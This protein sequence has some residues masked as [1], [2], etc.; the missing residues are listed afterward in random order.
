[1]ID[2]PARSKDQKSR[3]GV[4]PSGRKRA[5]T[6]HRCDG[7]S[8][9]R[10][11]DRRSDLSGERAHRHQARCAFLVCRSLVTHRA[12]MRAMFPAALGEV[13]STRSGGQRRENGGSRKQQDEKECAETSHREFVGYR[14]RLCS[15]IADT[16]SNFK[17][18]GCTH[19]LQRPDPGCGEGERVCSVPDIAFPAPPIL[20]HP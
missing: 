2:E 7:E 20:A 13:R 3:L 12:H 1:M 14:K 15:A 17:G 4:C 18:V 8:A 11:G 5:E 6:A 9:V 16:G 19:D 10:R